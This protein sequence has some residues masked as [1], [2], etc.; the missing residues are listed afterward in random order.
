MD[1]SVSDSD[2][3]A[4]IDFLRA[5]KTGDTEKV[6]YFFALGNFA[7][8]ILVPGEDECEENDQALWDDEDEYGFT[9]L[10]LACSNGH[11]KIVELLI[12]AG[13]DIEQRRWNSDEDLTPIHFAASLDILKYLLNQGADINATDMMNNTLINRV[14]HDNTWASFLIDRGADPTIVVDTGWGGGYDA[15][16]NA[17]EKNN[18][19]ILKKIFDGGVDAKPY[20]VE[21]ASQGFNDFVA[22]ILEQHKQQIDYALFEAA[23]YGHASIVKMLIQNGADV[24]TRACKEEELEIAYWDYDYK[25]TDMT[26]L[27]IAKE[28]G[29]VE[30]INILIAAGARD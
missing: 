12:E 18:Y 16:Q 3:S 10:I 6:K 28:K 27:E 9:P 7:H 20:L 21:L 15:V 1:T 4:I 22:E 29:H 11:L 23:R 19:D 5:V 24:N 14:I 17:I 30:V 25:V 13:A 2:F 26:P 8:T